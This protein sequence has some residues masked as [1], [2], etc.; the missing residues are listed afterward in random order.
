MS[1]ETTM[2]VIVKHGLRGL[3]VRSATE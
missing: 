1:I 2:L 3:V